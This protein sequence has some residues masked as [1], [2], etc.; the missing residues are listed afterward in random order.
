MNT[1][2]IALVAVL[3]APVARPDVISC[4]P[5]VPA[6]TICLTGN[7]YDGQDGPLVA[8][9]VYLVSGGITVPAGETLT[10][11]GAI[12]KFVDS[13]GM[14]VGGTLAVDGGTFTS[15]HDDVIGGDTNG[16]GPSLGTEGD[17]GAITLFNG[18]DASAFDGAQIFYATRGVVLS[19][20]DATLVDTVI[21]LCSAEALDLTSSSFP[22][23]TGCS[24]SSSARPVVGAP[25]RA[26]AGFLDNTTAFCTDSDALQ[27]GEGTVALNVTLS[28]LNSL[29][30]LGV[31][32]V[33]AT[34]GIDVAAGRTLKLE[35]GVIFKFG[36]AGCSVAQAIN[37]QGVLDASGV[38]LTSIHDDT[39]GGDTNVNGNATLPAPG[40]WRSLGFGV[41]SDASQLTNVQV[42]FAGGAVSTGGGPAVGLNA[43]DVTFDGLQIKECK[44]DALSL[45]GNSYPSVTNSAFVKNGGRPLRATKLDAL[46]GFTNNSASLNTNSDAPLLEIVVDHVSGAVVLGPMNTFNGDGVI[47]LATTVDVN[48][49]ASLTLQAG[50]ILK[51]GGGMLDTSGTLVCAN[52]TV[53][54]SI[55]DDTVGGD[56]NKDGGGTTPVP[57]DWRGLRFF[58]G[59]DASILNGVELRYGGKGGTGAVVRSTLDLRGGSPTLTD[60]DVTFSDQVALHLGSNSYPLVSN[61]SF[62]LSAA[63]VDGVPIGAVAG[64]T[65]NDAFANA[66]GNH[67]VVTTGAVSATEAFGGASFAVA[68]SLGGSGVFE[69]AASVQVD[70]GARLTIDGGCILKMS[71]NGSL[72][73]DGTLIAGQSGNAAYFTRIEDDSL[74]GDTN[75][76]GGASTPAKGA[77]VGLVLSSSSSGV[78]DDCALRYGGRV[79]GAS[80]RVMGGIAPSFTDV[81]VQY[82]AGTA[83]SVTSA[84]R[85][86]IVNCAFLDCDFAI[87]GVSINAVEG[88]V[89]NTASGNTLGDYMRIASGTLTSDVLVR[90]RNSPDR[91]PFGVA[92]NLTVPAGLE[93]KL[94]G[95][96]HLKFEGNHSVTVTGTLTTLGSQ[97]V[98]TQLTSIRDDLVGGDTNKD[99]NATAP[100]PG[101][102]NAV[103]LTAGSDDSLLTGLIVRYA[104]SFGASSLDLSG[105]NPTIVESSVQH[106]LNDALD[107]S[108]TSFPKVRRCSFDDCGLVAAD[109][110]PLGAI[111]GFLD[112][113]ASGNGLFD[114]IRVTSNGVVDGAE[115]ERH[116]AFNGDGVFVLTTAPAIGGVRLS[117]RQGVIFKFTATT[118]VNVNGA[119]DLDGS[120]FDPVVLTTI[121]DDGFGGDTNKDGGGT[122]PAAGA[123]GGVAYNSSGMSSLAAYATLRYAGSGGN[124]AL[125]SSSP[126]LTLN[127]VRAE[128][129]QGDGFRLSGL[130]GDAT[131]LVA[132]KC[133]ADGVELTGGA[134]D[135]L[136]ATVQGAGGTGILGSAG[137][138]GTV[139]S[140]ISRGNAV[141]PI[142]GFA[143]GEVF[144]SNVGPTHAGVNGNIDADP[145]FVDVAGGDLCLGPA[146]PSLNAGEYAVALLVRKDRDE[147][148]RALDH[149]LS[150]AMLPDMGAYE[151]STYEL[152]VAGEPRP[153][154]VLVF[155]VVGPPGTA[156]FH[157]G[158]GAGF[159]VLDPLGF[160]TVGTN[161][162]KL[163]TLAVGAPCRLLVPSDLDLVR[164][165]FAGGRFAVQATV[166]SS[167]EP[168]RG[169]VTQLYRT[170]IQEVQE[171]GAVSSPGLSSL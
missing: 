98:P 161:R 14:N 79:F 112:N 101:D 166:R 21:A 100:A 39:A 15:W 77:W 136:F 2:L 135:V 107:L 94:G 141:A 64:F 111:G 46:Q 145:Q 164:G 96:V 12:V 51:S 128:F 146:S 62:S 54:T 88:F 130:A 153:G 36:G 53:F 33:C 142:A 13:A 150:G 23:V 58:V 108:N 89:D 143:A 18:A 165:L 37:V 144:F 42:R 155:R 49:G 105:T 31:F 69:L 84:S 83:L 80:V 9:Q 55:A 162:V 7:V 147:R 148:S 28:P 134:F 140:S 121:T 48:A 82:G 50:L 41:D 73:V 109:N 97:S 131:N 45:G 116:N 163:H 106:G 72:N 133:G 93:L 154:S 137:H 126:D 103:F 29:S 5:Q 156:T 25:I 40:D 56:T 17:W 47:E 113:T 118:L 81:V 35:P 66:D 16:D 76:D 159:E 124:P 169:N 170:R 99:G 38:V 95:N 91:R 122:A 11:D 127:A 115:V 24:F 120:G 59:S 57:G 34:A 138:T 158:D 71:H 104:G 151:R 68:N 1:H 149:D 70:A 10:V 110:V 139:S 78:L 19:S 92:T 27:I 74:G 90:P 60:V 87:A 26:V 52:P 22:V 114:T 160:R 102:W 61:S 119:L 8:N 85:P 65:D 67:L 32:E 6:G 168:T 75:G 129:A 125:R 4:A 63:A 30:E 132:L 117:L 20:A 44:A 43:A 157:L 123:W 3:A 167:A 152:T 171:L 86:Q